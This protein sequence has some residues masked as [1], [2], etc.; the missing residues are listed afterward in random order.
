MNF[1]EGKIK[2]KDGKVYFVKDELIVEIEKRFF[3]EVKKYLEKDVFLGIRPEHIFLTEENKGIQ[4]ILEISEPLGK[5]VIHHIRI[6]E[7][8]AVVRETRLI[9]R[10]HGEKINV[11][12]PP[13]KIHL[14][15]K[16]SE[17]NLKFHSS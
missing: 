9:K 15:D 14:F 4:A 13:D 3:P 6:G 8:S 12:F 7:N 17:K 16:E 5:E 10:T 1:F 11:Y 2:E